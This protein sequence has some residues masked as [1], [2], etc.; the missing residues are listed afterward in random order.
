MSKNSLHYTPCA[1]A[2]HVRSPIMTLRMLLIS[3]VLAACSSKAPTPVGSGTTPAAGPAQPSATLTLK[4]LVNGDRAC[5]VHVTTASGEQS[6]E[7]DFELCPGGARDASALIGKAIVVTT[8]KENVLAASC[9]GD[10]DCGKSDEVD[11]VT[12]IAP[13]P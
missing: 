6:L 10:V 3:T 9:Q 4:E 2:R 11:L 13:A 7:G 5:Y 8:K 1:S 12:S